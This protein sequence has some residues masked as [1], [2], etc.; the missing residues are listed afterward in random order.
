MRRLKGE[1][2][3]QLGQAEPLHSHRGAGI[4]KLY[5]TYPASSG[6]VDRALGISS[7]PVRHKPWYRA[8]GLAVM[9]TQDHVGTV[10]SSDAPL[11]A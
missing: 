1:G 11:V 4:P 6:H 3:T 7:P 8:K 2:S 9:G 10:L 5:H